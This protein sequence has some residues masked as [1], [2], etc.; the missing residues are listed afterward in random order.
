MK[1]F[2]IKKENLM[3]C[4]YEEKKEKFFIFLPR[5]IYFPGQENK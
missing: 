3:E 1:V 4:C 2:Y 5:K